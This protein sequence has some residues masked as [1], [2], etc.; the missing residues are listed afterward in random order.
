MKKLLPLL[1]LISFMLT[2]AKENPEMEKKYQTALALYHQKKLKHSLKL[3]SE[4]YDENPNYKELSLYVGKIYYFGGKFKEANEFLDRAIIKDS[5][6]INNR[7]WHAKVKFALANDKESNTQVIKELE[8]IHQTDNSNLEVLSLLAKAYLKI[9]NFEKSINTYKKIVS[10]SDEIAL[11]HL[12]LSKIYEQAKIE[13]ES[14]RHLK[15]AQLI[16]QENSNLNKAVK[17]LSTEEEE[18]EQKE[19]KKK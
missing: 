17:K 13:T 5:D 6:N 8:E 10:Y 1:I 7:I 12:E 3:F 16:S 9:G 2:C 4:I 11:A 19:N 14:K 18:D 15:M